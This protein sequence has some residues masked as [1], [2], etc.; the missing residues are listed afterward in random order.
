MRSNTW[1]KSGVALAMLGLAALLLAPLSDRRARNP[2]PEAP[3]IR[4]GRVSPWLLTVAASR[5]LRTGTQRLAA[6]VDVLGGEHAG[7]ELDLFGQ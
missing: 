3:G 4:A 2:R 6:L 7:A 5:L 1:V